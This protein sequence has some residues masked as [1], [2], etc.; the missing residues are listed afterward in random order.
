MAF[1]SLSSLH[2]P[3]VTTANSLLAT[4]AGLLADLLVRGLNLGPLAPFLAALV[5][6]MAGYTVVTTDLVMNQSKEGSLQ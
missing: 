1:W 6:Y 4:L 2:Y 5:Y 3:Q